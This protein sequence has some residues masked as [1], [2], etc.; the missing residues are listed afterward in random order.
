MTDIQAL[1]DNILDGNR[2]ALARAITLVES[3]RLDHRDQADQLLEY[4]LPHTGNAKR[5]GISGVPG[6]GKS[7]FI[8]AFGEFILDK[9]HK[10]AVLAVDPSSRVSGG[11]ILGDKTR[12]E[13]L[14]RRKEAFIRPSPA[15]RSLG[16]VARRSREAMLVCEA[17]GFDVIF[18]ETVGVG[19]SETAVSEMTDMFL[20]LLLPSGGDELQGIKKGID[21]LADMVLVNK[22]DGDLEKT[23][24][25]SRADYQSA[26]RM[27]RPLTADWQVPVETISALHHKGLEESW[28]HIASFFSQMTDNGVL[29]AR[30]KSQAAAWLWNELRDGLVDQL[31]RNPRLKSELEIAENEVKSGHQSPVAASRRLISSFLNQSS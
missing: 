3:T 25:R 9:G 23:A 6:V 29:E 7:T 10:L 15:G 8:E 24:Q 2:R 5:I 16:G 19:Q 17:A 14:S 13:M 12:M 30:R 1:A 31:R 22:A 20:L 11:S 27:L 26:L 21:E 18:V 4:L 28:G